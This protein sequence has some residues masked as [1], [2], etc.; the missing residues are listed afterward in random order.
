MTYDFDDPNKFEDDYDATAAKRNAGKEP[1]VTDFAIGRSD[2]K[3]SAKSAAS[4]VSNASEV[5]KNNLSRFGRNKL[6]FLI[7]NAIVR[8][9]CA[10]ILAKTRLTNKKY[11]LAGIGLTFFCIAIL[12]NKLD[13]ARM[14]MFLRQD[15][16]VILTTGA[17]LQT[18][19]G[20]FGMFGALT[21]RKKF[22]AGYLLLLWV[23]GGIFMTNGFLAY[24]E[25]YSFQFEANMS[26]LWTKL[27][28]KQVT[29]QNK[30]I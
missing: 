28:S 29:I 19:L 7:F 6:I 22:L 16:M 2:T 15:I 21:H 4:Y 14:I 30:V 8:P 13:M 3:A 17:L 23:V 25:V 11:T 18:L 10:L 12:T 5:N 9:S 26:T 1:E 20:F 24:K 27:G